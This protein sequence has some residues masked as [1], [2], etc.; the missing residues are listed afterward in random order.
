MTLHSVVVSYVK[1]DKN[2]HRLGMP[3]ATSGGRF[4]KYTHTIIIILL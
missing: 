4:K 2:K 3:Q 1:D